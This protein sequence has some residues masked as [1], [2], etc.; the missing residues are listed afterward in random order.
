MTTWTVPTTAEPTTPMA[1]TAV[2]V[3][4]TGRLQRKPAPATRDIAVT[5]V[6]Q[7]NA[8]AMGKSSITNAFATSA[9][10]AQ[11]VPKLIPHVA[12]MVAKMVPINVCVHLGMV[13]KIVMKLSVTGKDG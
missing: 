4:G 5:P 12:G 13:V 11:I 3:T 8:T 6:K 2:P 7:P 1:R 9:T 10:P